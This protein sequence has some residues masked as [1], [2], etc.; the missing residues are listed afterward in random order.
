MKFETL[1]SRYKHLGYTPKG[2]E[3]CLELEGIIDWLY[4]THDIYIGLMHHDH[5]T[6]RSYIRVLPDGKMDRFVGFHVW[7]VSTENNNK[8][9]DDKY[10]DNPFDAKFNS[11]KTLYRALK[12][13][14]Y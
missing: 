2:L 4:K 14:R 10:F 3:Q 9:Y 8:F 12:F 5:I 7:N 13:Q 6:V 1:L 11:V